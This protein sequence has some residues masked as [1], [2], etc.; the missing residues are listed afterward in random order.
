MYHSEA[1]QKF[2]EY[3]KTW[4]TIE[5]IIRDRYPC[6]YTTHRAGRFY[7][8]S[9]PGRYD[10]LRMYVYDH[11]PLVGSVYRLTNRFPPKTPCYSYGEDSVRKEVATSVLTTRTPG[12]SGFEFSFLPHEAT[13]VTCWIL[14]SLDE[15]K[16]APSFLHKDYL[17]HVEVGKP[18][19]DNGYF[20]THEGRE[21]CR[22]IQ[23]PRNICS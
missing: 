1:L 11:A 13:E 4:E 19:R 23:G 16:E 2:P 12:T 6:P 8:E 21:V 7:F 17:M 14:D 18:L 9:K 15:M 20:W 22:Q 5:D 3:Q 10:F